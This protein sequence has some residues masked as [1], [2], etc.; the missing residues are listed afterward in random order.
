MCVWY[1]SL[2]DKTQTY[3]VQTPAFSFLIFFAS[4]ANIRKLDEYGSSSI[5]FLLRLGCQRLYSFIYMF[6]TLAKHGRNIC[7]GVL[8]GRHLHS[9]YCYSLF[10]RFN[11]H[12][13]HK[14]VAVRF[15]LVLPFYREGTD[16]ERV[17]D[18]PNTTY[19]QGHT[20]SHLF[21]DR[22]RL[23]LFHKPKQCLNLFN[24]TKIVP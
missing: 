9:S 19:I 14:S 5:T 12:I 1:F 15:A 16:K 23:G 6:Y 11:I 13:F 4:Q 18:L 2:S 17:N 20:K 8:V 7:I 10:I 21:P 24:K 3:Q 22:T